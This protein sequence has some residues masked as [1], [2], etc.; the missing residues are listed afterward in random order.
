MKKHQRHPE[1][2][3]VRGGTDLQRAL[4]CGELIRLYQPIVDLQSGQIVGAEAL[5]RWRHPRRGMVSPAEFIPI[6]EERGMMGA[7]GDWVLREACR[8]VIA[9][10]RLGVKIEGK[11]AINISALQMEDPDI[12]GR[13]LGILT[14]E[15]LVHHGI[16][17]RF[18]GKAAVG[19]AGAHRHRGLPGAERRQFVVRAVAQREKHHHHLD[20]FLPHCH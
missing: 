16:E 12:V 9:W 7:L 3:A 4:D 20:G 18:G 1:T 6:A 19:P 11:V 13:W 17:L 8:Q 14:R 2:E 15:G 5:L 10:E